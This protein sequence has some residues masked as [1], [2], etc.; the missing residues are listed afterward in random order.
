[1]RRYPFLHVPNL[2]D[3]GGY[4]A[5]DGAMT[6][7]GRF[8]RSCAPFQVLPQEFAQL[9][10]LGVTTVIDLRSEEEAQKEP[11]AFV[12]NNSFTCYNIPMSGAGFLPH[13]QEEVCYSYCKMVANATSM[14]NVFTTIAQA[15]G[16]VLFHC[17]AGKDRTGIV[18]ALL[19]ALVGVPQP[20]ILADYQITG[21]YIVPLVRTWRRQN[22]A[23]PEIAGQSRPECLAQF[24]EHFNE[25]HGEPARYFSH[26]GVSAEQQRA[27]VQKLCE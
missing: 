21:T 16:G 18:A 4:P 7:Y 1:M 14:R 19:L 24:F 5:K 8:L 2:R 22:P 23:F 3:L 6:Q 11:S 20:D 15:S 27:L 13:S 10:A 25:M 9:E 17:I 26:I 12:E